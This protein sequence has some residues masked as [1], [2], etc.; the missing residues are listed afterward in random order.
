MLMS[1]EDAISVLNDLIE[2]CK[3]GQEGFQTAAQ[4]VTR[5]DLKVLFT[6]LYQQRIEFISML[7]EHL[8]RLGGDPTQNGNGCNGAFQRGWKNIE[9]AVKEGDDDAI[10]AECGR[11][12][13]YAINSYQDALKVGLPA[14]LAELVNNQQMKI[15]SALESIK[16]FEKT[17]V[18]RA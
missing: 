8:L 15:K 17:N 12:E 4:A 14:D 5:A 6:D 10:I 13:D 18:I 1:N 3:G 2:T 9:T 7:Q 16:G 11:G